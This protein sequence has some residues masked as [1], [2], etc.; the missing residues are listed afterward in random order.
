MDTSDHT[1]NILRAADQIITSVRDSLPSGA[2]TYGMDPDQLRAEVRRLT[3]PGAP[4]TWAA[5]EVDQRF[6]AGVY[7]WATA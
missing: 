1:S 7:A 6:G 3:D 5:W 4:W 2:Q